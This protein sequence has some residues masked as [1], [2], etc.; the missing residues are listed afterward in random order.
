MV[1]SVGCRPQ[2]PLRVQCAGGMREQD[3]QVVLAAAEA[4]NGRFAVSGVAALE[5]TDGSR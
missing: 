5:P 1:Y 3:A 4:R 2:T